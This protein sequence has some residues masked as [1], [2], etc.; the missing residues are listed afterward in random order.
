LFKLNATGVAD[1]RA[2]QP[3]GSRTDRCADDAADPEPTADLRTRIGS[4][5]GRTG[6]GRDVQWLRALGRANDVRRRRADLKRELAAGTL[7]I[8]DVLA[9]PPTHAETAKVRQLLLA[10]PHLGP[11]KARRLLLHCQI[12]ESK[13]VAKLTD[14]QRAAL[15][16]EL[17]G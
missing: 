1:G 9:D 5:P 4:N 16:E 15:I 17:S 13:T 11:V 7:S 2:E 10:V 3:A 12:A 8:V 6:S 14:R